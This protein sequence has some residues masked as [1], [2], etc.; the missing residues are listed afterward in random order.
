MNFKVKDHYYKK[1]KK[2]NFMARSVYKLEEIDQK[3]HLIGS[4]DV[5]LDLGYYP[6]SWT[7][8][9]LSRKN[10]SGK[11]VGVDIQ[12]VNHKLAA[13]DRVNLFCQSIDDINSL[14]DL[15]VKEK[16]DCVISDM[17][18]KTTGIKSVDQLRSLGLVE[19]V[20]HKLEMFLALDGNFVIKVFD[21]NDA[22]M[23]LKAQKDKFEE[24]KFFKPKSTRKIS[25]EFFV[26]GK[27]FLG[28]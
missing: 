17:A 2:E 7:Q 24:F 26:I 25:K 12:D 14:E 3:Y 23:F 6:G 15:G 4:K 13:H 11:V 19:M 18:P 16:F 27:G 20:F 21:S 9:V 10:F 22:Q 8:Y 5:V 28:I 1:A